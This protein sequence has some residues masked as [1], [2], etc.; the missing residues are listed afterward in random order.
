LVNAQADAQARIIMM[1][2]HAAHYR[3]KTGHGCTRLC[4]LRMAE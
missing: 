3:T 2:E 4:G 1:R